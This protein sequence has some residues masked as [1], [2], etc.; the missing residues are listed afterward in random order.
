[1]P[2][3]GAGAFARLYN[4]VQDKSNGIKIQASRMDAEMD[5]IA[6]AL[7]NCVTRDGQSPA[8]AHI[9]MGGFRHTNVA[10]GVQAN[11]YTS[12][13]QAQK[14]AFAYANSDSGSANAYVVALTPNLAN[15]SSGMVVR[16]NPAN[17]NSGASTININGLGVKNIYAGGAPLK[18]G[19]IIAGV[20]S[21]LIYDGVQFELQQHAT[22]LPKGT[23]AVQRPLTQIL[24]QYITFEDYG[25]VGDGVTDDSAAIQA[26]LNANPHATIMV[27]PKYYRVNSYITV[28]VNSGI[29][30][31]GA[32]GVNGA[33]VIT[34]N[35]G[36]A[37]PD[38]GVFHY[39]ATNT[40][41]PNYAAFDLENIHIKGNNSTCHGVYLQYCYLANWRNVIIE[42]FYGCGLLLDKCQ[43]AS[44]HD[45]Q[46]QDC[47]RIATG[48]YSNV[49]DVSTHSNVSHAPL[50]FISTWGG[51]HCNSLKFYGGQIEANKVAPNIWI[52]DQGAIEI[53]FYNI[54]SEH[55]TNVLAASAP[56]GIWLKDDGSDHHLVGLRVSQ[57]DTLVRATGYGGSYMSNIIRGAKFVHAE[58]NTTYQ[59]NIANSQLNGISYTAMGGFKKLVNCNILGDITIDYNAGRADIVN[60]DISGNVS[61][62]NNGASNKGVHIYG[63]SITGNVNIAATSQNDGLY[64]ANIGGTL[65]FNSLNGRCLFNDSTGAESVDQT[66]IGLYLPGATKREITYGSTTP[67][68]GSRPMVPTIGTVPPMLA[69]I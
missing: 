32:G 46:I 65:T 38:K 8:T 60:C 9:P 13:A 63:G 52:N 64:Y 16:F 4:W 35:L 50:H 34:A 41:N 3:N 12:L 17:N 59:L 19:E 21:T 57:F 23:G 43:D 56:I 27:Q 18:G 66:V 61:V 44:F 48:S 49:S 1:M 28:P 42:G 55:R 30:L 5:G 68:S 40:S 20:I 7:S 69:T 6:T 36:V 51:D 37:T 26:C 29:K 11:E 62:T 10:D 31:M 25:A 58:A 39:A 47:G 14:G 15:Y 2:F 45:V 33:S 54:H 22:H 24:R 53:Y 67:A